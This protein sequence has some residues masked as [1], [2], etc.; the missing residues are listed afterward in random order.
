ML[1]VFFFNDT[2]TTEIY[3][4]SLHDA[5]RS[6]RHGILPS[7]RTRATFLVSSTAE[8]LRASKVPADAVRRL[9]RRHLD[10]RRAVSPPLRHAVVEAA[11]LEHGIGEPNPAPNHNEKEKQQHRI[12]DPTLARGLHVFLFL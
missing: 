5:L 10:W 1:S 3:T 4:L 6:R 11:L 2:A 7:G 8:C 12:R 9:S